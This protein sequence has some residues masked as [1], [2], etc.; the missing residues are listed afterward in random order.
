MS[1]WYNDQVKD[2]DKERADRAR[3]RRASWSV[4]RRALRDGESVRVGPAEALAG[5]WQLAVD[6]WVL[7][8]QPLPSY[9]REEMPG[10]VTRP[11]GCV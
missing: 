2:V 7:S 5:M 9:A 10:R 8:G 3:V 11:S 6:A 1:S 4:E